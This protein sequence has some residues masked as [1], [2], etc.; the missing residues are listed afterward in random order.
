MDYMLGTA[1]HDD[2]PQLIELRMA[3]LHADFGELEP[4]T[5]DAIES[6]LPDFFERHLEHDLLAYTMRDE[7]GTIVSIALMLTSEKPPNP[8]FPHGR[9]GTVFNVYTAPEHRRKGLARAV[10]GALIE[11]A[12]TRG[13]DLVELNATDDGYPLY[14]SIG[15]EDASLH[16]PLDFRL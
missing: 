11:D 4:E 6:S 15:F 2:I 16:R 12:K 14:R 5:D 13:L 8:R 7:C 10:M 1:T 3:Y 9:I